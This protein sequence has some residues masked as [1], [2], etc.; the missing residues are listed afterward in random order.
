M[1]KRDMTVVMVGKTGDGKS[2]TGNSL[3]GKDRGFVSDFRAASVTR[4]CENR[5]TRYYGAEL[6]VIDTPGFFDTGM[7]ED[8]VKLAVARCLG[9][10]YPGPDAFFLVISMDHTF[11]DLSEYTVQ[12]IIELFGKE[13]LKFMIIIFTHGLE[14]SVA[15]FISENPRIKKY[16]AL[17]MDRYVV[18][19]NDDSPGELER[20][21]SDVVEKLNQLYEA[22]GRT[23]YRN[24]LTDGVDRVYQDFV[25][26]SNS[27]RSPDSTSDRIS[28]SS[29]RLSRQ[30]FAT[31]DTWMKNVVD[32]IFNLAGLYVPGY[33]YHGTKVLVEI[34]REYFNNQFAP[35]QNPNDP[36][37]VETHH[38][39][40]SG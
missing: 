19:D 7:T 35:V 20:Q 15:D 23:P 16:L 39:A 27:N 22:N 9:M 26:G 12:R 24:H 33:M 3:L 34:G 4:V 13:I 40:N 2:A 28:R 37:N 14:K 29:D 5:C 32:V 10:T 36:Y 11:D 30:S 31:N 25:R 38:Q 18:I 1:L 17:C 8:A 6:N 21:M